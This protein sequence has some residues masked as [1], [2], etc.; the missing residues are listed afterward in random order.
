[1]LTTKR[2]PRAHCQRMQV[3][4]SKQSSERKPEADDDAE[5]RLDACDPTP[6]RRIADGQIRSMARVFSAP[7]LIGAVLTP[8]LAE[9]IRQHGHRADNEH[10]NDSGCNGGVVVNTQ[11]RDARGIQ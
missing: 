10:S 1:L 11:R 4:V 3:K 6:T 8:L 7:D 2:A 9:A 5:F